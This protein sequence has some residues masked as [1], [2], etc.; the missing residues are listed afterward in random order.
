MSV[1]SIKKW[2]EDGYRCD[3]LLLSL[4]VL[5]MGKMN[6]GYMYEFCVFPKHFYFFNRAVKITPTKGE[7]G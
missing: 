4:D 1:N 3:T 5:R 6:H 2:G 7:M